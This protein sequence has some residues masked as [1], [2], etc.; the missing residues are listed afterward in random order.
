M[1]NNTLL[2]IVE[3]T[4]LQVH[5]KMMSAAPIP[6]FHPTVSPSSTA[7]NKVPQMG[8][9]D[10]ITVDSAAET[11]FIASVSKN[12]GSDV[13]T[14]PVQR[15]DQ[16]TVSDPE[17][18]MMVSWRLSKDAGICPARAHQ[19]IARTAK[20]NRCAATIPNVSPA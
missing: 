13:V 4:E 18:G 17:G 11:L 3:P 12:T 10:K 2:W 1:R 15:S 9:A 6:V 20:V 14:S 16:P 7:A 5:A 19:L 8:S